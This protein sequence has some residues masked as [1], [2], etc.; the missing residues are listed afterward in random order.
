[1]VIPAI[2]DD[3][4]LTALIAAP[5]HPLDD[6]TLL[7]LYLP[8]GLAQGVLAGRYFL[9]RCG[10]GTMLERQE[11]WSIYLRRALFIATQRPAHRRAESSS[12]ADLAD[13]GTDEVWELIVPAGADPGYRWLTEQAV[14]ASINLIG[15]LGQGFT[16]HPPSRNLLLLATPN[17]AATLLA[18]IDPVLDRGGRVTLV[19]QTATQDNRLLPR[20][21]LPV[22]VRLAPNEGA[23]QRQ[24]E[25]TLSWADQLGAALPAASLPTLAD[26][27]RRKRFRLEPGFA[28][29]LVEADLACGVGACLACVVPTPDGGYTRA[30]VHGPVFDLTR[31]VRV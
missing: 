30:C 10:A 18:L 8:T 20:L 5:P 17:R 25:E 26:A 9:A 1:M 19:L 2:H 4:T 22:E 29:V 15:P 28:Q 27:I 12:A 7:S 16:V 13:G 31:L 21:P 24:L 11:N 14:G 23:W 6:A 3:G